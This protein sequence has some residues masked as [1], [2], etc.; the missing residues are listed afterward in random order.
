[1]T[2][3]PPYVHLVHLMA[4]LRRAAGE[5]TTSPTVYDDGGLAL[6]LDPNLLNEAAEAL[7]ALMADRT[8][9]DHYDCSR[10]AQ[11]DRRR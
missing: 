11:D 5:A 8:A 1:M 2:P 3:R 7:E 6:G 4:E 10:T 9:N